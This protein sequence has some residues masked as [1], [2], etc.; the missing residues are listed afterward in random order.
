MSMW[1]WTAAMA[2]ALATPGCP[3][4]EPALDDAGAW[5]DGADTPAG[6]SDPGPAGGDASGG[7]DAG[8][9]PLGAWQVPSGAGSAW[10]I[11]APHA[12]EPVLRGGALGGSPVWVGVGEPEVVTYFGGFKIDLDVGITWFPVAPVAPQR[13]ETRDGLSLS[14]PVEG[15]DATASLVF[16]LVAGGDLRVALEVDGPAAVSAGAIALASDAGES[17]FGLGTQSFAMDLRGGRF[18]LWTQEQGIGKRDDYDTFPLGNV[19]EA[20]YAP[21]GIWHS[22]RGYSAVVGHDAFTELDLAKTTADLAVVRS[23]P[24]LPSFVLVVGATPRERL[25]AIADHYVGHPPDP[26]A[27]VFAPWNDSVGGPGRLEEV[28]TSLRANH[29]P[30]SALWSEDWIGGFEGSTGYRLSYSWSWDPAQYPDL[31][32]DIASLHA[33]GFAFLAYFN[34]FVPANTARFPAAD[35]AGYLVGAPAGGSYLIDDPAGR[36]AGLVDLTEPAATAWLREHLRVAA[37]DLGVDGWMAD[38]TEWLPVDAALD[39]GESAW[40]YHNRYPLDWQR[41]N[42]DALAAVHAGGAGGEASNNWTFFARSGW[43][44]VNGGSAGAAATMWG[45]DQN[46]DWGYDDGYPTVV[47]LAANVGLAGVPLFGTDIGG[48]SAFM[49]PPTTKELFYRWTTVAALTPLMRTHHGSS[50]C[51]NWSFDRDAETLQH[52]RRWAVIH[53][54]LYPLLRQLTDVARQTALPLV[55]HP[56]LVA[57]GQPALWAGDDYLFFLGDDLLVAPVLVEGALGREVELPG[58]GWWPLLGEAPLAGEGDGPDGVAVAQV[59]APATELPVFVRPGTTVPLLAEPVDSFYGA[60]EAGVSELAD[61]AGR[62]ALALYPDPQG[63]LRAAQVGAAVVTGAGWGASPDWSAA[64]VGGAAVAPCGAGEAAPPCWLADG[65][66]VSGADVDVAVGA[67]T[68]TI[69]SEGAHTYRI[70][71]ARQGWGAWA[72]PTPVTDLAPDV[73]PPCELP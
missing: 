16:S 55:R 39:S 54:L 17:F 11:V 8:P 58:R 33:R 14:W 15:V 31:P 48:Y 73:P 34:T 56:W 69:R 52:F 66:W 64:T 28:A 13:R 6:R 42:R 51:D 47:P 18:P 41:A 32:T 72:D 61:Q 5:A 59:S 26:P 9:A 68:L 24:D 50:E 44:S 57:P 19:R 20:A 25:A 4:A 27:W 3:D 62:V 46:T 37:E 49:T 43:A 23:Y 29:I 1:R 63:A 45:G 38:F 35:I 30:S 22:S 7:P 67:A 70:G 71:L 21:M 12:V 40:R 10:A 2:V 65:L 36:T 60:S 53:T